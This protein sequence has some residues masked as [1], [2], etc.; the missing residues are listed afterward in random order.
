MSRVFSIVI[1]GFN[2]VGPL[3]HTLRSAADAASRM[4]AGSVEIILVDDGS[5]PPLAEQLAGFDPGH[6]VTHLRQINQ[7]SIIARLTGLFAATGDFV[8]FLDSDDLIHPDKLRLHHDAL[9]DTGADLTHDDVADAKLMPDGPPVYTAGSIVDHDDNPA[10]L[11]LLI[12]PLPHAPVYRRTWLLQALAKPI[13]P[14]DRRMDPSGDV[15]LYYNLSV[16]PGRAAKVGAHLTAIGPHEESRYSQHWEKLGAASLLLAESF[17][18][19][20]PETPATSHA[21]Q[22]VGECAFASWRRLPRDYPPDYLSRLLAVWRASP[23]GPAS[24]LGGPLFSR[25]SRLIGPVGAGRLLRLRNGNYASCRTLDADGFARLIT[26]LP[27]PP[28]KP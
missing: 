12:Q 25:M 21:R 5:T 19:L 7:G 15:W 28:S 27:N 22:L 11:L 8:L 14:P 2:R 4:P 6:P 23:C 18:H 9:T 20:C 1:P 10:R 13:V 16:Q 24:A 26:S 3:K 17:I